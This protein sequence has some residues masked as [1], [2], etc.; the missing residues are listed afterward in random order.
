MRVEWLNEFLPA[1]NDP[2]LLC[3]CARLEG[4]FN[5]KTLDGGQGQ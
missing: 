2:L 1:D 5:G 4:Q 3:M